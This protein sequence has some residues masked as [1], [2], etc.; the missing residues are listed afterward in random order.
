MNEEN[1]ILIVGLLAFA[2]G[3]LLRGELQRF[4]RKGSEKGQKEEGKQ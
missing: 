1:V 3:F 2:L 4:R